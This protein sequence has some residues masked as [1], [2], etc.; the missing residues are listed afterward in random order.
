MPKILKEGEEYAKPVI[1]V[2]M[3][4]PSLAERFKFICQ[5]Q[6]PKLKISKVIEDF[7][8]KFV[9]DYDKKQ[10]KEAAKESIKEDHEKKKRVEKE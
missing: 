2:S 3:Q 6:D 8:R 5:N 10:A 1:S 9:E 7:I 4:N